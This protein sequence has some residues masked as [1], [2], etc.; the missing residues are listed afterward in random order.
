MT[1]FLLD[2]CAVLWAAH[3]NPLREP[4]ASELQ[5]A[6]RPGSSLYVSP[7]TALE[8]ATLVAKGKVAPALEPNDWFERSCELPF[9]SRADGL[10]SVRL[11][12]AAVDPVCKQLRI[13]ARS[14]MT[15]H[16]L[17]VIYE[18]YIIGL[19]RLV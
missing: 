4:A 19:A 2:T 1:D 3:K 15:S 8:I 14:P 18:R 5:E 10:C 17:R 9:A 11:L 6:Y 13:M 12:V 16:F 7:I